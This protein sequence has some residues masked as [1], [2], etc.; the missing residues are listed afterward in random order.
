MP[1]GSADRRSYAELSKMLE[2]GP[3]TGSLMAN[4]TKL[5]RFGRRRRADT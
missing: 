1:S 3:A 5:G 2:I 4:Q